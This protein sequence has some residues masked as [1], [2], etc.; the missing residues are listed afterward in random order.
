DLEFLSAN[1]TINKNPEEFLL[2]EINEL[3]LDFLNSFGLKEFQGTANGLFAYNG[4]LENTGTKG[5]L[6]IQ[7]I[8]INNFLIGD[9]EAETEFHKGKP[10]LHLSNIR[11][12]KKVIEI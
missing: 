8:H 4:S 6:Q 11:E 9:I 10:F 12:G 1:G 5:G 7:G 2:V 3:N